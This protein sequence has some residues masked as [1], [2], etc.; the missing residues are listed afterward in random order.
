MDVEIADMPIYQYKS[1]SFKNTALSIEPRW[2]INKNK[3]SQNGQSGD[4]LNGIYL[5]LLL[6]SNW[7]EDGNF[8]V[9]K[10]PAAYNGSHQ[11]QLKNK[12]RNQLVLLNLG[13][14]KRFK[15]N[16]FFN[17]Q[18][19]TG[20][21]HNSAS[22]T[23][24]TTNNG[25][26]IDLPTLS[27]WKW[28]LNYQVSIG[29]VIGKRS[30]LADPPNHFFEYYEAAEDMWKIDL[31]NLFQGLN[32]KGAVGQ[33]EIAYERKI[34]HSVFSVEGSTQYLY[35]HNF[36]MNHFDH[37]FALQVAPRFYYRLKKDMQ[38]GKTANNLSTMYFSLPTQ[39]YIGNSELNPRKASLQYGIAWGAQERLFKYF[40]YDTQ[41][42]LNLN[43]FMEEE[44]NSP[45]FF[46]IRLGFAF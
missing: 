35:S 45:F 23:N 1:T 29:A 16:G 10:E 28:L 12:G 26:I 18:L 22:V 9:F 37:Q 30:Q 33:L 24:L 5:G 6:S 13:W 32:E 39:W 25:Q 19:G 17:F 7:W 14:Q 41:F 3:Q 40:F 27:K 34:N 4:N 36:E 11:E 20:A 44:E 15:D 2:Y 42:G 43:E 21:S 46:K 31:F 38:K 8:T